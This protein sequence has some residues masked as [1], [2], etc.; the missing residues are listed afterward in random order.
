MPI[1]RSS[2]SSPSKHTSV[3]P[4]VRPAHSYRKWH[5]VSLR[6]ISRES[7]WCFQHVGSWCNYRHLLLHRHYLQGPRPSSMERLKQPTRH[8]R[9][10]FYSHSSSHLCPHLYPCPPHFVSNATRNRRPR[11]QVR[12]MVSTS[13]II[14]L[15]AAFSDIEASGGIGYTGSTNCTGSTC[16]KVN[17]YYS[18]VYLQ[19]AFIDTLAYRPRANILKLCLVLVKL[20]PAAKIRHN[21]DLGRFI[22]YLFYPRDTNHIYKNF[23]KIYSQIQNSPSPVCQRIEPQTNWPTV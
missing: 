14:L 22:S 16:T 20:P 9:S 1:A 12:A 10:H 19:P 23:K 8:R 5:R 6:L 11:R 4:G 2:G 18:Q 3:L 7:A 17:D 13:R 21:R 15:H